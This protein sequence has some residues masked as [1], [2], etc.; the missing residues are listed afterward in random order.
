MMAAELSGRILATFNR[1]PAKLAA[2]EPVKADGALVWKDLGSASVSGDRHA[3]EAPA[4]TGKYRIT[5]IDI[6]DSRGFGFGGYAVEHQ[7]S[8]NPEDFK[9]RRRLKSGVQGLNRLRLS[10][11]RTMTAAG[12]HHD[13]FTGYELVIN[14]K[15]AKAPRHHGV[16]GRCSA[17]PTR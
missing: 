15:T 9:R 12:K 7:P 11:S 4:A 5:P 14:F 2:G 16:P 17:A 8:D 13:L 3:F 6:F 10:R 1:A